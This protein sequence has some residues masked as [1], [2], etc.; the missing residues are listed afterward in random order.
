VLLTHDHADHVNGLDDIRPLSRRG[1]GTPV[2]GSA[3]TLSRLIARFPYVFDS[4]L[5]LPG[6][7]KP[8]A[9]PRPIHPGESLKIGDLDILPLE[10]NH[11]PM[12]VLGFRVGDLGYVT[13]A[14]S[15]PKKTLDALRGV[16]LMI[17]NALF[18]TPHP[19]HLSIPEAVALAREI[20]ADRTYLTHLTHRS[21][22]AALERELPAGIA[23]A[24]DGLTL[25]ID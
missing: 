7:S 25:T 2:Y 17:L 1:E 13:D 22:H 16:K 6:T 15:L 12:T 9:I 3:E 19:T 21:S 14:K 18:P 10:V 11:G 8:Q 20:G 24:Y 5:P 23:P 4:V